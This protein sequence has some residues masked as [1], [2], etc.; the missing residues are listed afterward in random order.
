MSTSRRTKWTQAVTE[1]EN[2]L[3][4]D[5]EQRLILFGELLMN[6]PPK[7]NKRQKR[8]TK[9]ETT[10]EM[11]SNITQDLKRKLDDDVELTPTLPEKSF[12]RK[13]LADKTQ[14]EGDLDAEINNVE[15]N[16]V[17]SNN[18]TE[19]VPS[20][21][22]KSLTVPKE[23]ETNN[24]ANEPEI[25]T[26]AEPPK[27]E[28]PPKRYSLFYGVHKIRLCQICLKPD[29]VY[30][31]KG[32]CMGLFH[33]FC[34]KKLGNNSPTL[35]DL[36]ESS[37]STFDSKDSDIVNN[38]LDTKS[39]Y[40]LKTSR[41]DRYSSDSEASRAQLEDK[42]DINSNDK[43]DIKQLS[44]FNM[45]EQI[46]EKMQQVMKD[47][48]MTTKYVLTDSDSDAQE[49]LNGDDNAKTTDSE[50]SNSKNNNAMER[51]YI[52]NNNNGFKC[53]SCALGLT[54]PCF[55]C[56]KD[57]S[58]SGSDKRIKCVIGQCGKF[59]HRECLK[60]W[61]QTKWTYRDE[62]YELLTCPL[63]NCH[64]C[65]S[66]DP[67]VSFTRTIKEKLV[68][69]LRCPTTYHPS[70]FCVPAGTEIL[71]SSQIICPK[72]YESKRNGKVKVLPHVNAAWCFI[73][74][75]GGSLI[76]CET[77]PASFHTECLKLK[78]PDGSYLCE[79]C[80]SGRL[81]LYDE[82]VWVK[83]GSYRWWPAKIL[84]PSDVPENVNN[85]PHNSQEF[86]VKF[87][88]SHDHYWVNRGRVFLFQEG[89]SGSVGNKKTSV[90]GV[91]LKAI[92][93][94]RKAHKLIQSRFW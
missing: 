86:V 12:K 11:T 66:D 1:A 38:K 90:D 21:L 54:P 48:M 6:T 79:E 59:Y 75:V 55:V 43:S 57:V 40:H 35:V 68:K 24:K 62:N 17:D 16:N 71:S 84:Y 51:T 14:S 85:I 78:P 27:V 37:N 47:L 9:E 89:D 83:L 45:E 42:H 2:I 44:L 77:C 34:A 26:L 56:G 63:H 70:H 91:F 8:K 81:P 58:R 29:R 60:D 64:M 32:P 87:F 49:A 22:P 33:S 30:R 53:A 3:D 18:E 61:P 82:I 46:D 39:P 50:K 88:G 73:C 41:K 52:N 80:E 13:K 10:D 93:E 67:S 65:I 15:K 36:E 20:D 19:G 69:C 76:C 7:K 28:T 74:A 92:E 25:S 94:A 31:C 72:H 23:T 4:Y 5:L